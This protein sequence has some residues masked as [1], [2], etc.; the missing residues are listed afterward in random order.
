[1]SLSNSIA[2]K[3]KVGNKGRGKFPPSP[4]IGVVYEGLDKF[5][6]KKIV[7]VLKEIHDDNDEAVLMTK[8]N[9]L[10]SVDKKSLKIVA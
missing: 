6:G 5:F 10:V 1:M 3:Y 9:K 2:G 7:G 8:E 4:I